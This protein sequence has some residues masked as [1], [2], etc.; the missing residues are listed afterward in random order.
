MEIYLPIAELPA[1]ILVLL[2]LGILTGVLSGM[3]GVGGGF[4]TTPFLILFGIP[5]AV[6]VSSSANQVVAT[7]FSGFLVHNKRNN[8]DFRMGMVL[9]AGGFTGSTLGVELFNYLKKSGQLDIVIMLCYVFFLGSIGIYMAYESWN[10]LHGKVK[11]ENTEHFSKFFKLQK[12]LPL[13]V[14]FPRS[15]VRLSIILPFTVGLVTGILAS[16]MGI[17][18]GFIIIPAM[19]YILS[20]PTSI[21]V[22]TSLFQAIFV[23]CNVT[24]LYALRTQTVDIVL[25]LILL[26]G[27]VIGAQYGTRIGMKTSPERIRAVLACLVL[28]IA[29]RMAIGLFIAPEEMYSITEQEISER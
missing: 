16:L 7:S 26:T 28:L 6:A 25:A 18:G 20:M 2:G 21:V 5:P 19:I 12:K 29:L 24:F 14:Y 3:L 10:A 23:S 9:L 4:L 15:K 11:P 17:G 8:V 27:S 13:Q 22:G 1:N